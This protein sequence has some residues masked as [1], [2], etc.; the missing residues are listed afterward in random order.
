YLDAHR[1]PWKHDLMALYA[2]AVNAKK[3]HASEDLAGGLL[4]SN[5]H[6]SPKELENNGA[7]CL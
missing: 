2:G 1:N 6:H 4:G 7:S 3:S 5:P